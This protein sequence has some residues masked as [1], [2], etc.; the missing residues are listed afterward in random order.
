MP[1]AGLALGASDAWSND[2]IGQHG[3]RAKGSPAPSTD[4]TFTIAVGELGPDAR[5]DVARERADA[6][7]SML[8]VG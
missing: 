7:E 6:A 1:L 4:R 8:T 3:A 5:G 2:A